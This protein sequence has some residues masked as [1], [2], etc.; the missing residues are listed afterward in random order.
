VVLTG[1]EEQE[2]SR[3]DMYVCSY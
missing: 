3:V 1:V 2:T